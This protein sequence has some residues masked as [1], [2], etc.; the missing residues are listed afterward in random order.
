MDEQKGK[1][2]TG[3]GMGDCDGKQV[4]DQQRTEWS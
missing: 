3:V 4:E 2:Y 1:G